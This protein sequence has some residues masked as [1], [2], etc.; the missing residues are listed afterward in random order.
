MK[1]LAIDFLAWQI[2]F[3][4]EETCRE[5][6]PASNGRKDFAIRVAATTIA[7]NVRAAITKPR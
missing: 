1:S 5:A 4:T 2:R 7:K 3:G 6:L